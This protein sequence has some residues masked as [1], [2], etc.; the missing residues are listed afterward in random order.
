M[1]VDYKYTI[2]LIHVMLCKSLCA[3][4]NQVLKTLNASH[5][6]SS[7][8]NICREYGVALNKSYDA[9]YRRSVDSFKQ[10]CDF[11]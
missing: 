7:A 8:F 5:V 3:R 4:S 1:S 2:A 10:L 11:E 9:I 6:V